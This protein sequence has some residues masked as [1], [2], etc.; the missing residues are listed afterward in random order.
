MENI[1]KYY[2]DTF[3]KSLWSK[4]EYQQIISSFIF[5]WW[6]IKNTLSQ[7]KSILKLY[8]QKAEGSS[9][10]SLVRKINHVFYLQALGLPQLSGEGSIFWVFTIFI[11]PLHRFH[12][13]PN[14]CDGN[15]KQTVWKCKIY[16]DTHWK[17][18]WRLWTLYFS[19]PG[20]IINGIPFLALF[21]S[22]TTLY[23]HWAFKVVFHRQFC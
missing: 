9:T 17:G 18:L 6:K 22:T 20:T 15:K 1:F 8:N 23:F 5:S 7:Q 4:Y 14:V 2:K 16:M 11:S 19:G 13:K 12:T 3:W 21:M 10:N